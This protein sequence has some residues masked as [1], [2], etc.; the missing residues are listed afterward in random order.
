MKIEAYL[1]NEVA[2]H[3]VPLVKKDRCEE[4]NSEE[5]LEVHHIKQFINIVY[6]ALDNEDLDELEINSPFILK[7]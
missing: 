4:C 6:E 5:N 2:E 3:F 1:R 7:I